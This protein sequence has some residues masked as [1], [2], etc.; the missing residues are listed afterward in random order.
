VPYQPLNQQQTPNVIWQTADV[1]APK[2]VQPFQN[3]SQRVISQS[4]SPIKIQQRVD[5]PN[6]LILRRNPNVEEIK[7]FNRVEIENEWVN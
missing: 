5:V 2:N 3:F 7:R 6:T 4:T 1:L